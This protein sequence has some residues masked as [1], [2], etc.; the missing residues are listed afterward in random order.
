MH[1]TED[2]M[3]GFHDRDRSD[4]TAPLVFSLL[5][6]LFVL[7]G[8][9]SKGSDHVEGSSFRQL[10]VEETRHL[11]KDPL[12]DRGSSYMVDQVLNGFDC[13]FG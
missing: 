13:Y 2:L 5:L 8:R 11:L 10:K 1:A 12:L 7:L 6:L 4:F 9:F 3:V